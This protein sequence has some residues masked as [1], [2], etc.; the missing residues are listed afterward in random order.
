MNGPNP[1]QDEQNESAKDS[2][3]VVLVVDADR[4]IG[5]GMCE[6]LEETIFLIDEDT[7]LAERTR[8]DGAL[9]AERAT[10]V[11]VDRCPASAI[12]RP[13][14]NPAADTTPVNRASADLHDPETFCR[15]YSLTTRSPRCAQPTA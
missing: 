15:G 9:A 2:K 5:S 13:M 14:T 4:C 12:C 11:V 8:R 3:R 7:N 1:S 6:M 10:A